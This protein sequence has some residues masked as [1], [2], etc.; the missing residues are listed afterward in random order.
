MIIESLTKSGAK[1]LIVQVRPLEGKLH[2]QILA[3]KA[4]GKNRNYGIA[5]DIEVPQKVLNTIQSVIEEE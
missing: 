3:P 1:Y 5:L 4:K 2:I